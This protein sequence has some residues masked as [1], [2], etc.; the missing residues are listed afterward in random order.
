MTNAVLLPAAIPLTLPM[1]E[2]QILAFIY[3]SGYTLK[4]DS[5]LAK[6][7]NIP[8]VQVAG[9][10]EKW[11]KKGWVNVRRSKYSSGKVTRWIVA[12]M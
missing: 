12:A 9:L 7:G 2:L 4:T 5:A 3:D 1:G 11:E 8:S 10:I 6:I